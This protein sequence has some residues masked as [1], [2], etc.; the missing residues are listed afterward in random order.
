MTIPNKQSPEYQKRRSTANIREHED[1][2]CA[3]QYD[4]AERGCHHF[5]KDYEAHEDYWYDY[6]EMTEE[7]LQ[8]SLTDEPEPF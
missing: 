4:Y 8:Q 7:E 1:Y 5:D 2:M 6:K 3:W